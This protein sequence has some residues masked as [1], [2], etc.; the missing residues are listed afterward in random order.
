[1]I[2][3][4]KLKAQIDQFPEDE[5]SL[6]ELI[7]RLIFIEKLE[8]RVNLSKANGESFSNDSVQDQIK[9]WSK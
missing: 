4:E 7:E 6:D 5:I 1:M 2:S 9:S 3:K 8:A